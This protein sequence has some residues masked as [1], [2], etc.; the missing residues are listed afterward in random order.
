MRKVV[1]ERHAPPAKL[2]HHLNFLADLVSFLVTLKPERFYDVP[3]VM[4]LTILQV[5]NQVMHVHAIGLERSARR[6]EEVS[7]DLVDLDAARNVAPFARLG[8]YFLCPVL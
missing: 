6:E 4:N 5:R 7:D 8:L 2:L 1:I 3:P